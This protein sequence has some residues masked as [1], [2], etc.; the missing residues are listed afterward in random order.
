MHV[1]TRPCTYLVLHNLWVELW[2]LLHSGV[3][4]MRGRNV[5]SN[6]IWMYWA[7]YFSF[8]RSSLICRAKKYLKQKRSGVSLEIH[9]LL[10]STNSADWAKWF[11]QWPSSSIQNKMELT[12]LPPQKGRLERRGRASLGN[13]RNSCP[14]SLASWSPCTDL[15]SAGSNGEQRG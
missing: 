9:G 5:E 1:Y 8:T 4:I 13:G 7:A 2:C 14:Y 12:W 15:S 10:F 6:R 3:C 11:P